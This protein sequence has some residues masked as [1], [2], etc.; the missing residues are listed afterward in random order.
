MTRKGVSKQP[1]HGCGSTDEHW[2]GQVCDECARSIKGYKELMAQRAAD[3][4][5]V[6][7]KGKEVAYALPHISNCGTEASRAVQS[8]FLAL[9]N[10]LSVPSTWH[11]GIAKER[12]FDPRNTYRESDWDM[13]VRIKPE[14]AKALGG[15]Y[16][17]VCDAISGAYKAGH[18]AGRNL[19]NQLASGQI[20]ADEY[21]N[22]A[23]RIE[24]DQS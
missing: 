6:L 24:K 8:G 18:S 3:T 11:E 23:L 2:T 4:S 5:T 17:A 22:K 7:M 9:Q 16:G 20:T 19:L 15:T 10:A 13:Q 1:C 12:I 21:N 14:H